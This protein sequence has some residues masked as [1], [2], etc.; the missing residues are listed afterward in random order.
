MAIFVTVRARSCRSLPF[1]T[2]QIRKDKSPAM[3]KIL[4]FCALIP[5][6]VACGFMAEKVEGNGQLA[7]ETREVSNFRNVEANGPMDI[8]LQDQPG[9]GVKIEADQNLL[10][11]IVTET[12]DHTLKIETK[13]G[14]N[15]RSRNSIRVYISAP[16]FN[17]VSLGGSGNI[18]SQGV[19]VNPDEMRL[20][21]DGSGNIDVQVN[22]PSLE[23]KMNGSGNIK[24]RGSA[25]EWDAVLSGSGNMYC[26]ELNTQEAEVSINGSG[27]A[28][29][30][31][32][33]KL[34]LKINGSGQIRYKGSPN[35][36]SHING[37]GSVSK[38][39]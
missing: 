6:L 35:V 17:K 28:E 9:T 31:A 11:Y 10:S 25:D 33:K 12:D 5:F 39:N 24:L 37:S 14:F 16:V 26:F 1:L 38:V 18:S 36:E 15:L 21:L 19:L 3:Q 4:F 20:D 32:T 27:D 13:R 29:V 34:D 2:A 23:S 7:S 30:M 22:T 8:I